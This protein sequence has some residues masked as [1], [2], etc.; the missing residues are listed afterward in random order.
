MYNKPEFEVIELNEEDVI[1]TSGLI[2]G[3]EG[4]VED[5]EDNFFG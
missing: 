1:L 4:N 3:G 5:L 2:D